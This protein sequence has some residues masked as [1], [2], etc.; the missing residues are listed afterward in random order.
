MYSN[1]DANAY[2]REPDK[3]RQQLGGHLACPV[4]FVREIENL[5][6]AGI[7][8]FVEV[9]PRSVLTHLIS[10]ILQDQ[11]FQAIALDASGGKAGG[12]IVDLAGL[13]CRLASMGYPVALKRWGRQISSVRKPK[14]KIPLSGANYRQQKPG[15]HP[16]PAPR[17]ETSNTMDQNKMKKPD[18]IMDAFNVVAEGLK[19]IQQLQS[20]TTQA[21]Q[22]FLESQAE[23]SR[24]LQEIMRNTQR[25]A[26]GSLGLAPQTP[27]APAPP[28]T[29]HHAPSDQ[30]HPQDNV[31]IAP[32]E[33]PTAAANPL[34]PTS[35]DIEPLPKM[36][37]S[38]SMSETPANG[39]A[40]NNPVPSPAL[41]DSPPVS[42]SVSK[43]KI[44][45]TLLEV[46]SRLTGY[47]REMLGLDMDIEAELGIDSIKRV[48]ILSSLEEQLPHLPPVSPEV[49]GSLKTLG[50][51]AEFL[52]TS[53]VVE[54][55]P[56]AAAKK[57][58][59]AP[60]NA[61]CK[62][63]SQASLPSAAALSPSK[64]NPPDVSRRVIS[65]VPAPAPDYTPI[66]ID[67]AKVVYVTEEGSGLSA[68]IIAAFA[69]R[70]IHAA[71]IALDAAMNPTYL[72]DA[73][74]LVIV[75][76]P[77]SREMAQDLKMAFAL[78]KKVGQTLIDA[79][80]QGGALF[81]TITRLDGAFGC[82]QPSFDQP[83]QGALA[84]LAKTAAI[85]WP[86]VCCHAIDMVSEPLDMHEIAQALVN[87]I[88]T[89]GP[90]EIGLDG[91]ARWT[92]VLEHAPFPSGR[93]SLSADDVVLI[94]GGARGIAAFAAQALAAR[95][96]AI[97][98]LLGRS[99]QPFDEPSWLSSLQD[100]A[101]MKKAILA[102][103]FTDCTPSPVQVETAFR[104]YKANREIVDSLEKIK[105][106][107]AS[108][109]YYHSLDVRHA[110]AVKALLADIRTE[111]GPISA[112][113]HA[114]GVLEDRLIIEK[115]V[116]QFESVF[117][118]KVTGFLNLLQACEE[119][120]L[121]YIVAFS[122]VA[123]RLG[124][125]GQADYA[126]ANEA[127]NKITR[128]QFARRPDCRAISINWGPWDG[129]M[130]TN[131]L[132]REFGRR[133][134]EL[135][136]I[137]AGAACMLHE[138]AGDSIHPVEVV[139]GAEITADSEA[140][141][142]PLAPETG[143]RLSSLPAEPK[144]VP[145]FEREISIEQ[146]PVLTSH[147]IDG[148]PVVPLALM[149]ECFAHAA[150]HENP[151]LT[152]HGLDEIRILKGIRLD[153]ENVNIRLLTAKPR[154]KG[155][156][157]EVEMQLRN[158]GKND[159]DLLYAKT[160]AVLTD[161]PVPIPD[162]K[163]SKA[164]LSKISTRK[165]EDVYDQILFHGPQLHAL[166]RIV[167]CTPRGMVAHVSCAPAPGEWIATPLRNRWIADPLVLDGAFQMASLWCFE[168][169]SIVSLPSYALCY[170]QYHHPFPA[171]E[172]ICVL[173]IR[174]A[175]NRKM[176][177]DF[178]FLDANE[179]VVARLTGYE[180]IM[181]ESL[182]K[183]FKACYRA[184]A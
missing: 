4:E 111:L 172:V 122:S 153:N 126:M 102:H 118:T 59:C 130:V 94:S 169:K 156:V 78:A 87:E 170:R 40:K 71:G 24:A 82:R 26:E 7:R 103:D 155:A 138:M 62:V 19:S 13:L 168:E 77:K 158:A 145:V 34:Q 105:A 58:H 29:A 141:K 36:P 31:G 131:T 119:D 70:D 117:D 14:M 104:A 43:D 8:T 44:S 143:K 88:M 157:Y 84:G 184:S 180:A 132:K 113:I 127:L 32:L 167:S 115:T 12:G 151:G 30:T 41:P 125:R 97:L 114:A 129:G 160:T 52:T 109:V 15:S 55:S 54:N 140:S 89:P 1:T 171:G 86:S 121:K 116:E 5:Y 42:A 95:T 152:F 39:Y 182:N 6:Q 18:V 124:N 23:T 60:Q 92:L 68:Q 85:E 146:Y 11:R 2:S 174:E 137:D 64:Q 162:F 159:H 173:E 80:D 166:Q 76:D 165:I 135:I 91:S 74:G 21:H 66:T 37:F 175:T 108:G 98:V 112:V 65:V 63:R 81:S 49:M 90:V 33:V 123:A 35:T 120:P 99:P 177:G 50:Q 106:S 45:A 75:L 72:E 51:I 67:A 161:Q 134:I 69:K 136:P 38:A 149:T 53:D 3:I 48:E 96:R 17:I 183:A 61:T 57:E 164:M 142:N 9:G 83:L 181:D 73:A 27:Q 100:E 28:P 20:Q 10:D 56:T 178:T 176:R 163:I 16:A 128:A 101:A 110:A 79:G 133:N 150:L 144:L 25:L 93:L 148:R 139:I 47:P 147:V 179:G 22:K 154:K 107:G 46:V